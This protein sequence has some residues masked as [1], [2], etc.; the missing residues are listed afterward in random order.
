MRFEVAACVLIAATV[1]AESLRGTI[2]TAPGTGQALR[3]DSLLLLGN[4]YS[5][6]ALVIPSTSSNQGATFK[7]Y[8]YFIVIKVFLT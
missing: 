7:L 8:V 5:Q 2:S 4:N 3:V 6:S 1:S